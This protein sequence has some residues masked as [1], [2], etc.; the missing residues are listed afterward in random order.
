MRFDDSPDDPIV[1][2]RVAMYDNISKTYDA[3]QIW[4]PTGRGCV[5]ATQLAQ[6]L[7]DDLELPFDC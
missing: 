5:Y 3:A 1:E 4:N 7:T 6:C 2:G